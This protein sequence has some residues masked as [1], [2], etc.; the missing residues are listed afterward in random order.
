MQGGC[1]AAGYGASDAESSGQQ[2]ADGILAAHDEA[3]ITAPAPVMAAVDTAQA[4]QVSRLAQTP[5]SINMP[6]NMQVS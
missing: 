2:Q 6:A 1:A 5:S 4:Q 3:A